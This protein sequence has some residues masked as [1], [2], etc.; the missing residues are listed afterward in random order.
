RKHRD[1]FPGLLRRLHVDDAFTATRLQTVSRNRRLLAI[2]LLGDRQHSLRILRRY[3]AN[4]HHKVILP[5]LD[6]A[7]TTSGWSLRPCIL[8]VE[9]DGEIVVA[10]NEDALRAV[11]ENHVE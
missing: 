7:S 1:D 3:R 10:G 2:T 6:S 4:R 5:Q 8:L 11:C 9:V